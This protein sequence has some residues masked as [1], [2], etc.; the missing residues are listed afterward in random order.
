MKRTLALAAVAAL[1]LLAVS[2]SPAGAST[3]LSTRCLPW[4]S[5]SHSL[6]DSLAL[7]GGSGAVGK[8][9]W[10]HDHVADGAMK[11]APP[12]KPGAPPA[13]D[14]QSIAVYFHEI[15]GT[16]GEGAL[17]QGMINSQMSVLQ[18]AFGPFGANMTLA[19]TD[20]TVNNT[21]FA[22]GPARPRSET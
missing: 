6:F 10:K 20:V 21:W 1:A 13:P 7:L 12:H 16:G 8:G 9:G 5:A 4:Q 2:A 19:G 18:A 22:A 15:R 14:A 3:N 11:E 17:T